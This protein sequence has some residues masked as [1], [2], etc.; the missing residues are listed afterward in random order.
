MS[1]GR[2]CKSSCEM[3]CEML[4]WSSANFNVEADASTRGFCL[5]HL[6]QVMVTKGQKQIFGHTVRQQALYLMAGGIFQSAVLFSRGG[7]GGER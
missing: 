6:L 5:L 4:R 2:A 7:G 1:V 3:D